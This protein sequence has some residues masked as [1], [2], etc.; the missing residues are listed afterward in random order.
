MSGNSEVNASES[1]ESIE[2]TTARI[3]NM[4]WN[5]CQNRP[6]QKKGAD[7]Y[8]EG[9][10]NCLLTDKCFVSGDK[11]NDIHSKEALSLMVI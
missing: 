3:R 4:E 6:S 11:A 8:T 2:E 1:L 9:T 7:K 5:F 10:A